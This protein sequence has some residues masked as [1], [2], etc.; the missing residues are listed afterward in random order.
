M[1]SDDMTNNEL[2]ANGAAETQD[3]TE[4]AR[5]SRLDAERAEGRDPEAV[6]AKYERRYHGP[7]DP[8]EFG[9]DEAP[10]KRK[11]DELAAE[12]PKRRAP[13]WA[14]QPAP[15]AYS[16]AYVSEDERLW[17]SIAHGS[18][19][20]TVLGGLFTGG[21]SVPF[22][23]FIP[24]AIFLYWRK[25]SDFVAFQALQAFA[26]QALVTVGIAL[27]AFV[28]GIVWVVGLLIALLLMIVLVGFILVPVWALVGVAGAVGLALAPFVALIF[29]TVGALQ[30]YAG[31]DF[32]YPKLGRWLDRQ[33]ASS[34]YQSQAI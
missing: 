34:L 16:A 24:L 20:L 3:G 7:A 22:S 5:V 10:R 28:G 14:A 30:T 25:R 8:F 13:A 18:I 9:F 33:L 6:V 27:A 17:S 29:G 12:K 2:S 1:S 26:V 11:N 19:W 23:L 15:R 21:V 31:R 4:N 32:Q